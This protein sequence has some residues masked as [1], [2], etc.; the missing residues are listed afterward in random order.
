MQRV[1]KYSQKE[2]KSSNEKNNKKVIEHLNQCDNASV[3]LETSKDT[4]AC[5]CPTGKTMQQNM[6]APITL[7]GNTIPVQYWCQ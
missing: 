7:Y 6:A 4:S 2:E 5:T 1:E 3:S